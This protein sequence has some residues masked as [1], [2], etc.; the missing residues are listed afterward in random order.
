[1]LVLACSSTSTLLNG[2]ER[3]LHPGRTAQFDVLRDATNVI[4]VHA[5]KVCTVY[6]FE[7]GV[8]V[9]FS[10]LLK[11]SLARISPRWV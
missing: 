1:M 4:I 6:F 2:M 8:Y 5:P 9:C 11:V 7:N 10:N 3:Q